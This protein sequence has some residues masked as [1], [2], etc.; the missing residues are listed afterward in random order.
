MAR[1]VADVA[2]GVRIAS[3]GDA[4]LEPVPP[5]GDPAAVDVA[6]LRVGWFANDG[7]FAATPAA[8][9]AVNEA[10]LALAN[11]GAK[12]TPWQPPEPVLVETLFFSILTA[13]RFEGA[14]RVLGDSE[15][16]PRIKLIED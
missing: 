15:R 16:D 5:L 11:R 14:R 7:V 1:K 10:A 13:D 4:P 12:V 6:G 3:G 2:L 8:R 9:R